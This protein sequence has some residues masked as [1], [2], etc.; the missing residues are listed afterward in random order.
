[1]KITGRFSRH[2]VAFARRLGNQW[3]VT[4]VP[5]F[6]AGLI[7]PQQT[8]LGTDIWEDTSAVLPSGAPGRWN[9][10]LTGQYLTIKHHLPMG[11]IFEF[12]PAALITGD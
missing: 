6:L 2:V 1:L 5:R 3:C 7:T 9:S 4:A 12:F 11:E 8:P 10:V